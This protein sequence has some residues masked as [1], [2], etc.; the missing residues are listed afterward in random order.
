MVTDE[1][2]L[3][4]GRLTENQE[5]ILYNL[6]LRQDELGRLSTNMLVSR[7][8]RDPNY[9]AMIKRE[10]LTYVPFK[11]GNA[12][13]KMVAQVVVTSKGLRYCVLHSEEIEPLRP[14][15][16]AGRMRQRQM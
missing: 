6:A 12:G 3:N 8:E 1:E 2:I 11:H 14:Y 13:S 4:E 15:D 10:L 5:L 9:Q 16:V 7:I